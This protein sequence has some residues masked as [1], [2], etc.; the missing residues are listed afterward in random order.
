MNEYQI[1][2][3][4]QALGARVKALEKAGV[5]KVNSPKSR[6]LREDELSETQTRNLR[7]LRENSRE[8]VAEIN[9]VLRKYEIDLFIAHF[10]LLS[11]VEFAG[12]QLFPDA[13]GCCCENGVYVPD[14]DLCGFIIPAPPRG[15]GI[16]IPIPFP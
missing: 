8:I 2:Q 6:P 5:E 4:V 11:Q 9:D 3:D 7:L 10:P 16:P 13:G 15:P 12:P 1:G 14:C